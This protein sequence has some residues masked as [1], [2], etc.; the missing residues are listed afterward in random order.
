MYR[1]REREREKN[2]YVYIWYIYI[3]IY[4]HMNVHTYIYIYIYICTHKSRPG[5]RSRCTTL[6]LNVMGLMRLETL[7]ELK[8]VHLS[9]ST[10]SSY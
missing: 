5:S 8:F 7:I 1:D 10:L 6:A 3:Y 2:M 9:V 4:V